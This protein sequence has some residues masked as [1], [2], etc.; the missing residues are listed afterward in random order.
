MA[1][2]MKVTTMQADHGMVMLLQVFLL[3]CPN[4]V[5]LGWMDDLRFY[6]LFN[7]ISVIRTMF[8]S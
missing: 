5:H 6:I 2:T 8:G 3:K 4:T 7:S 1:K